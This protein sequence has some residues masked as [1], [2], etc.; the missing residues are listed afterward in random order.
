MDTYLDMDLYVK[1]VA[2]AE[3]GVRKGFTQLLNYCETK[4]PHDVWRTMRGLEVQR[5]ADSL[6]SQI[7]QILSVE[8]PSRAIK[9]FWFGLF[10]PILPNGVGSCG[11]YISGS[12]TFDPED[13]TGDWACQTN[14]SYLPRPNKY[15]DSTVLHEIY[16]LIQLTGASP[17]GEYVLCLGYAALALK[18][19]T[20]DWVLPVAVGFDSGDFILLKAGNS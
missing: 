17:D 5:D 7:E 16:A 19:I 3:L 10:N 1:E 9:A 12:V 2:A 18:E 14:D 4:W 13:E 15:L 8:P 20:R 6:R 11:I